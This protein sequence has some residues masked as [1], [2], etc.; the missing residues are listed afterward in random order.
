MKIPLR[1]ALLDD[2]A[3]FLSTLSPVV[4]RW[5]GVEVVGT[6]T[7][8]VRFL[9]LLAETRPDVI[10]I[11]WHLKPLSGLQV[12]QRVRERFP[13]L[14]IIVLSMEN[15]P[16][17]IREALAAGV[18][19]FVNKADEIED[20]ENLLRR[21]AEGGQHLS[22][23]S[24]QSF[25]PL[26]AGTSAQ[27]TLTSR[28]NEVLDLIMQEYSSPQIAER[29]FVSVTTVKTHRKNILRKL[30]FKDFLSLVRHLLNRR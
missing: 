6:A 20:L 12:V 2:H 4:A 29:L 21:V 5:P 18:D 30:G 13:A 14:R 15:R 23:H 16:E 3:L 27:N 24:L 10:L 26:H 8:P 11:D 9:D 17:K 25:S 1:V 28:E 19:G 7:D 22:P